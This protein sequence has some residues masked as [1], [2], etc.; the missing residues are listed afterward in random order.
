MQNSIFLQHQKDLDKLIHWFKK[1][2]LFSAAT[3]AKDWKR[4]VTITLLISAFA[5]TILDANRK[6]LMIAIQGKFGLM[7]VILI[8]ASVAISSQSL[9]N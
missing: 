3:Q 4:N 9:S 8:A 1:Y 6:L 7:L 5:Q 2:C